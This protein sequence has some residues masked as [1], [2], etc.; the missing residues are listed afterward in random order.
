MARD[1]TVTNGFHATLSP[2]DAKV[3]D[4]SRAVEYLESDFDDGNGLD[5][6]MSMNS[7]TNG[8]LTYNDFLIRPGF[9]GTCRYYRSLE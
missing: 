5:V 2:F 7:K 1:G 8:G 6:K 9:I 3:L 4:P